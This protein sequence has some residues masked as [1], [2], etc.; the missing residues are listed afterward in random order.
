MMNDLSPWILI[1][2]GW[3]SYRS[4]HA[5]GGSGLSHNEH[6]TGVL[7]G[8]LEQIRSL[9]YDPKLLSN[10]I[11][12]FCDSRHSFRRDVYPEYKQQRRA[13]RT[14][15]EIAMR[16]AMDD[17]I[18]VVLPALREIGFPVF[19][20][21][22]LE[23]DDLMAMAARFLDSNAKFGVIVTADGDLYQCITNYVHWYDPSRNRYMDEAAFYRHAEGL[24]P[25]QWALAKC[26]Y[27]CASDNVKGVPGVGPKTALQHQLGFFPVKGKKGIALQSEEGLQI[28]ARNQK[29]ILLPHAATK[30]IT[31]HEPEYNRR[32]FFRFCRRYGLA[33]Y[34]RNPRRRYWNAFFEGLLSSQRT[35]K[36]GEK[37]E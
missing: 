15:K 4:M 22:G 11:A 27:G 8:L 5:M 1:D 12:I 14:D 35:R 10:R 24:D 13:K 26:L 21:R 36:R 18:K 19:R 6:S 7:Y 34:L 9:A 32:A 2:L 25:H 29:L 17:Q 3:L 23:S 28:I 31:L 20:Q 30:P 37:Y 33:S 16:R